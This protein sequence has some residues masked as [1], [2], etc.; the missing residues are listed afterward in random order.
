MAGNSNRK[1]DELETLSGGR[2]MRNGVVV[3]KLIQNNINNHGKSEVPQL[4][5]WYLIFSLLLITHKLVFPVK[6]LSKY[7]EELFQSVF[8]L[9]SSREIS[10]NFMYIKSSP[11]RLLRNLY[12]DVCVWHHYNLYVYMEIFFFLQILNLD[13]ILFY[14]FI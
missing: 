13:F 5:L 6:L 1:K 9:F 2:E 7:N 11:K 14:L 10:L 4:F 3:R 12:K 8:L